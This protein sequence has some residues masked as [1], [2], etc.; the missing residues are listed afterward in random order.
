MADAPAIRDLQAGLRRAGAAWADR[1]L[2]A[3]LAPLRSLLDD[4]QA[5]DSPERAALA[6]QVAAASGQ[7]EATVAEGLALG[8]GAWSGEALRV[9]VEREGEDSDARVTRGFPLTAVLLAGSIPMPSLL[10][11]LLPLAAGSAVLARPGRHDPVTAPFVAAALA[12][13]EPLLAD[14]L[15]VC[16]FPREDAD[17]L[18]AFLEA[19]CVVATGSDETVADVARRT[20]GSRRLVRYGHRTS[21]AVCA[22]SPDDPRWPAAA[23]ALALDVSLWDQAGCLSPIELFVPD[24]GDGV[25][26]RIEDELARAL[27][28]V[29]AR[30]PRGERNAE[31]MAR[32]VH[33]RDEAELRAAAAKEVRLRTGD[34]WALVVEAD[35]RARPAPLGRFLRVRP[36]RREALTAAL[37]PLAR[38]LAAVGFEGEPAWVRSL[39]PLAPSRICPLGRMQAPPLDWSHDGQSPLRPL[40]RSTD[41]EWRG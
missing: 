37:A 8:F 3:R 41:R 5:A 10:S 31:E 26:A 35:T 32:F 2:E 7:H 27:E 11:L 16:A 34:G 18:G 20:A 29:A 13:R 19:D 25:A 22:L 15:R 39:E 24:E 17:T 12:E 4:L 21:V 28:A 9:L 23:D 6:K 14:V 38:H 40:L 36:V 30:L 1:P 33:E